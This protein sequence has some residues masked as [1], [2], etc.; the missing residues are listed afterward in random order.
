MN[1][2][3]FLRD[4][5]CRLHFHNSDQDRNCS[6]HRSRGR[7]QRGFPNHRFESRLHPRQTQDR[8]RP[9]P[10]LQFL[11]GGTSRVVVNLTGN[12]L[13][14]HKK[15]KEDRV[16]PAMVVVVFQDCSLQIRKAIAR[17]NRPGQ[18]DRGGARDNTN[19]AAREMARIT[20]IMLM[21]EKPLRSES[22][23]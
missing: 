20:S 19:T 1:C 13:I 11:I 18:E 4:P 9:A 6:W 22:L 3:H 10:A 14:E 12:S 15:I 7:T 16:K 17:L 5:Q 2:S 23:E 8:I 21:R